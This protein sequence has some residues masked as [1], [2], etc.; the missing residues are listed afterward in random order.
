[1]RDLIKELG[2]GENLTQEDKDAIMVQLADS[3]LKRLVLR[4]YDRLNEKDQEEFDKLTEEGDAEKI[5]SFLENKI[6]D[7]DEMRDGIVDELVAEMRDFMAAA[8]K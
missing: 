3:L 7:L 5:N 2:L 4:V 1:M 8:K 6:P